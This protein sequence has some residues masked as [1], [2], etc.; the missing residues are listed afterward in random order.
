M[1]RYSPSIGTGLKS[2]C[3]PVHCPLYVTMTMIIVANGRLRMDASALVVFLTSLIFRALH[4]V[5]ECRVDAAERGDGRTNRAR[6]G[7]VLGVLAVLDIQRARCR[8]WGLV[9]GSAEPR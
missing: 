4:L 6:I 7:V 2:Q 8:V 9:G 5:V 3:L 1:L